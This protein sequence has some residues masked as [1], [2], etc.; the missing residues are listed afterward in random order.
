[1]A[2]QNFINERLKITSN[3]RSASLQPTTKDELRLL[4]EKEFERQGDLVDLNHI[5][6][7]II[8]DM[9]DLFNDTER[10]VELHIRNIKIDQWDVSNVTNMSWM[11]F[12]CDKFLGTGAG[13]EN[14]DTSKVTKTYAMFDGCYRFNG[15][16]LDSWD[17]SNVT[18]MSSMF[19]DCKNFEGVGLGKWDVSNVKNMMS[20]FHNC[21]NFEGVGL[22][23]WNTSNVT[24]ME[25]MFMSCENLEC[26]GLD[27][28][29]VSNVKNIS[30]MFYGCRKFRCN[31][32]NWDL[33]KINPNNKKKVFYGCDN[34]PQRFR[35]KTK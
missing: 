15:T 12:G 22:E 17:V 26:T 33:S 18:N 2:L 3:S 30:M 32:S 29:D 10:D 34:Q 31:L 19:Y 8:T 28:W 16:G 5:D 27:K 23:N 9:S 7:S 24:N 14:W 1:M 4:I 21:K 13:F 6:T 20:M 35:A 25:D 11:F